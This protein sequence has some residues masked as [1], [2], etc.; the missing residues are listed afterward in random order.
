M[1]SKRC[2]VNGCT[3]TSHSSY[4]H[5]KTLGKT[6]DWSHDQLRSD[7]P[8]FRPLEQ[9]G[10]GVGA[11]QGTG[12]SANGSTSEQQQNP[13]EQTYSTRHTERVS[14]MILPALISNGNKELRVNVMLDPCSTS[15]YISEEAAEELE[16][17]GQTLNLTIAGTGG[18]EIRK[19]SRQVELTVTN[20]DGR[21]SSPLL[22]HV[23]DNIAGDTPAIP[24]TELKKKWPQLCHVPFENVS[25]GHQ[26]DVMIG[27]DHPVFHHVLKKACGNQPNDPVAWLTN[28]G[29]VCFGPT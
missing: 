4:L 28:L 16:L 19:C 11:S 17:H 5:D 6:G 14:L 21:F 18:T 7:A 1:L 22:V 29:W 23:L 20:L 27:S 10:S 25:R 3:S 2:G 26:V 15:S 13:R 8:P 24:W 9:P 12:V